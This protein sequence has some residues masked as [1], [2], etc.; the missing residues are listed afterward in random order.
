MRVSRQ[1][2]TSSRLGLTLDFRAV[3]IN[4]VA[5]HIEKESL[6]V[7][8][9]GLRCLVR[10]MRKRW[11]CQT[12]HGGLHNEKLEHEMAKSRMRETS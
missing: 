7:G 12:Q 8:E 2:P 9:R 1:F 6:G 3:S 11:Q 4:L 10:C 5:V